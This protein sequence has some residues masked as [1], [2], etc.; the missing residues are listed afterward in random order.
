MR[1]IFMIH[2]FFLLISLLVYIEDSKSSTQKT[3][4]GN[5]DS[6]ADM[7]FKIDGATMKKIEPSI[8]VEPQSL[9][10]KAKISEFSAQSQL[11]LLEGVN[12]LQQSIAIAAKTSDVGY[13]DRKAH[14]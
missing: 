11:D 12:A 6:S 10:V 5:Y 13:I 9:R 1:K 4:S 14:V 3:A 2:L 8:P 7:T